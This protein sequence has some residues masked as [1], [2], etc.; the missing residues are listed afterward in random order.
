LGNKLII[1]GSAKEAQSPSRYKMPSISG[2]L[3]IINNYNLE[4]KAKVLHII[5]N[6][7]TSHTSPRRCCEEFGQTQI[8]KRAEEWAQLLVLGIVF[9]AFSCGFA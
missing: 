2:V 6:A 9:S 3:L 8:S 7:R 1:I 5:Q 4:R